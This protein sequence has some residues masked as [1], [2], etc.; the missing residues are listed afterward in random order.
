MVLSN[1]RSRQERKWVSNYGAEGVLRR[2]ADLY[3]GVDGTNM[4]HAC[5]QIQ[6]RIENNSTL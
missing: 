4:R 2:R 5:S 3:A 6:A 1:R